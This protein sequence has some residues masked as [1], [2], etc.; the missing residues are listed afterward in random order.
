MNMH[1]K[2]ESQPGGYHFHCIGRHLTRLPQCVHLHLST[3]RARR[4]RS[5]H[6]WARLR[7]RLPVTVQAEPEQGGLV[8]VKPVELLRLWRR[9]LQAQ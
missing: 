5:G 3:T 2:I 6:P 1:H 4:S 9:Q 8:A 7:L